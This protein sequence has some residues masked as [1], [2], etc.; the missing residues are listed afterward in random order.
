MVVLQTP[1]ATVI[2]NIYTKKR[3]ISFDV[4]TIVKDQ[5][6]GEL[7]VKSPTTNRFL[8]ISPGQKVSQVT[9]ENFPLS[10]IELYIVVHLLFTSKILH[11]G[12]TRPSCM[13]VIRENQYYNKQAQSV[14]WVLS[15]S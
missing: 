9:R 13:C 12:N 14:P 7:E 3:D 4:T 5:A 11:M 2:E 6:T 15:I 1:V 8:D 10:S